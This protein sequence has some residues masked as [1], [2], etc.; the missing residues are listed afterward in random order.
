MVDFS[1]KCDEYTRPGFIRAVNSPWLAGMFKHRNVDLDATRKLF[2]QSGQCSLIA[3][4]L[5]GLLAWLGWYGIPL[6]AVLL[7]AVAYAAACMS[8]RIFFLRTSWCCRW[9]AGAADAP[10]WPRSRW[11][12][13]MI[14]IVTLISWVAAVMLSL[15]AMAAAAAMQ[16]ARCS[17]LRALEGA[18]VGLDEGSA[19][20]AGFLSAAS[21]FTQLA[22]SLHISGTATRELLQAATGLPEMHDFQ[23][24]NTS[25]LISRLR[26]HSVWHGHSCLFCEEA[27]VQLEAY[28]DRLMGSLLDVILGVQSIN[29]AVQEAPSVAAH[30][31]LSAQNL[32]PAGHWFLRIG[33]S[34]K[35]AT[36]AV[37]SALTWMPWMA[38]SLTVVALGVSY[39]VAIILITA[40]K[41]QEVTFGNEGRRASGSITADDSIVAVV[42]GQAFVTQLTINQN[43]RAFREEQ[44]RRMSHLLPYIW[45]SRT[46]L[47]AFVSSGFIAIVS[48]VLGS[49]G[50]STALLMHECSVLLSPHRLRSVVRVDLRTTPHASLAAEMCLS[51]NGSFANSWPRMS[52]DAERASVLFV[53][54]NNIDLELRAALDNLTYEAQETRSLAGQKF[55]YTDETGLL[56][57]SLR[58]STAY[59]ASSPASDLEALPGLWEFAR[60]INNITGDSAKWSFASLESPWE[61]CITQ[62][63]CQNITKNYP[64]YLDAYRLYGLLP[65][66]ETF[67]VASLKEHVWVSPIL[68]S[69]KPFHKWVQQEI[70]QLSVDH[71]HLIDSATHLQNGPLLILKRQ[72]EIP[73]QLLKTLQN[74]SDCTPVFTNMEAAAQKAAVAST[75][76]LTVA[77]AAFLIS[78]ALCG[79]CC[80]SFRLWWWSHRPHDLALISERQ[81]WHALM[82]RQRRLILEA[83]AASRRRNVIQVAPFNPSAEPDAEPDCSNG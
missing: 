18:A 78:A 75:T 26:S 80:T 65:I 47:L 17:I 44:R 31:L 66:A 29:S 7:F 25:Q 64:S 38:A 32:K 53:A 56:P 24:Q 49:L 79:K 69:S 51:L 27:W 71:L 11:M 46:M 30:A 42:P 48:L 3:A 58:T 83:I 39:M 82:R 37:S 14:I 35:R 55:I 68:G 5:P 74:S 36:R 52:E 6:H 33:G 20:W 4:D 72:W 9:R 41:H 67:H 59:R 1:D 81:R 28:K 45:A 21:G 13:C 8:T 15:S 60:V 12:Y 76:L 77:M 43:I 16:E 50:I 40:L 63:V 70:H 10:L 23:L 57:D 61:D 73:N 54:R 22:A 62:H 19:S 34:I 2:C